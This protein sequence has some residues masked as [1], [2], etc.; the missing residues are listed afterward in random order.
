[1]MFF[2]HHPPPFH[3]CF[4]KLT[5]KI[6]NFSVPSRRPTLK[7]AGEAESVP[8]HSNLLSKNLFKKALYK[9][10]FA[11]YQQ[12]HFIAVIINDVCMCHLRICFF[13]YK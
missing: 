3:C 11:Q 2:P 1:M 10:Y 12:P 6:V 7:G 13:F 9:Y 4:N 8:L 5:N